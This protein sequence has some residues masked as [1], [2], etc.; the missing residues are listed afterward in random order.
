MRP[1]LKNA[2]KKER[3]RGSGLLWFIAGGIVALVIIFAFPA[4]HH[5]LEHAKTTAVKHARALNKNQQERTAKNTKAP[6][7]ASKRKPTFDFYYLLT[8]PTQ[9]LTSSESNEVKSEPDSQASVTQTGSYVLQVASVRHG[10]DADRLK[11]QL[12][13]WGIRSHVQKVQVQGE[14]W[15][16]VRIGPVSDLSHLNALRKTLAEHHLKPL[17]IRVG[18]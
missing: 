3:R 11:A 13:L 6:P 8:H 7:A 2:P 16:R 14:T 5:S 17:L 18:N 9:I 10:E 1:D 4:I 12:A 15:H